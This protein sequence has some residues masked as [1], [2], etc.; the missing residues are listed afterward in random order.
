VGTRSVYGAAGV[1][2]VILIWV[3]Y[4]AQVFFLG[5]EFTYV[6]ARWSN[7]GDARRISKDMPQRGQL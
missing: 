5:A 7:V 3:Y 2:M 6:Y 4:S 1:I